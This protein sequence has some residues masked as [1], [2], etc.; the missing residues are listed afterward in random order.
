[1]KVVVY[2]GKERKNEYV[3][4]D[5]NEYENENVYV[6]DNLK[7]RRYDSKINIGNY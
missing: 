3:D 5:D 4:V 2:K 6:D 1:M 7:T